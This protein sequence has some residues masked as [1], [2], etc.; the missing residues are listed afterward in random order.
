MAITRRAHAGELDIQVQGTNPAV[1][2]YDQLLISGSATLNGTLDVTLLNGFV[3]D[4]A[5]PAYKFMTFASRL[6]DFATRNMPVQDGYTLFQPSP[7]ATEYDLLAQVIV[8]SNT[9][10]SGAGSLSDA[11]NRANA[12]PDADVIFFNIAGSGVQTIAPTAALPTSTTP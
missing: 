2:D 1:P 5:D 6:G 9:L 11:I 3:P 8:V 4:K 12:N 7:Q 10:N